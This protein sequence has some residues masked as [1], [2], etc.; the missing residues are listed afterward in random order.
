M[1]VALAALIVVDCVLIMITAAV[2]LTLEGR[3]TL[4]RHFLL[5]LFTVCFTCFIHV[6]VMFYLIGTGKDIRDAVEDSPGLREKFIPVTRQLKRLVFPRA[7]LA[8]FLSILGVL[9]GGEIHSRI[10][11]YQ[12]ADGL[13]PIRALSGW[14]IHVTLM[15]AA[16]LANVWAFVG[17]CRAARLNRSAIQAINA[18]LDPD[19]GAGGAAAAGVDQSGV[20]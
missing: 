9:M 2:G 18:A 16:I 6:L 5:G 3:E 12:P 8:I 20:T 13:Y 19:A 4:L 15:A 14:W 7:C 10:V 1:F 11:S 17:E